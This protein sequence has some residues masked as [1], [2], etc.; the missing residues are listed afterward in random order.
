MQDDRISHKYSGERTCHSQL[1]R[2][3][4]YNPQLAAT[5]EKKNTTT[6]T[7]WINLL[8]RFIILI[9]SEENIVNIS[10]TNI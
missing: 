4:F 6:G 2:W 9:F 10:L 3:V 8:N 7:V 1:T 5:F